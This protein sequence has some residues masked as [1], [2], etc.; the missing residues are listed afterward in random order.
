[1]CRANKGQPLISVVVPVYNVERYVR[2]AIN[3]ITNQSLYD[4]QIII[5]DD[6]STDNSNQICAEEAKKDSRISIYQ[7]EHCGVAAARNKGLRAA[8]GKYLL[9]MDADDWMETDMLQYLYELAESS[10]AD[11]AVCELVKEYRNKESLYRGKENSYTVGG[12][13]VI[14]EINYN[15]KFSPFLFNKLFRR[16]IVEGVTFNEGVTIG[17]DYSFIME[18]L[19]GNPVVIKGN[20]VKYHY[21]QR[22]DSVSYCGFEKRAVAQKNR[23]NYESTYMFLSQSDSRLS[24]GALAYYILQEMAVVISM[25][26]S[27]IY[28]GEIIEDV[29]SNIKKHLRKYVFIR[30]VPG[31]LKIC[32]VLLCMN[33]KFL[34]IPYRVFFHKLR[35]VK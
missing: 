17:E 21:R 13:E 6:G 2:E 32:A 11:I 24:C 14:D 34:L 20:S 5:I 29:R 31:Y 25:V 4:I 9:F 28:D 30:R 1:M 23:A 15:G 16:K 12:N 18:I 35:S 26:K 7:S 27:G 10:H 19:A 33:E 8:K 3:S 22:P